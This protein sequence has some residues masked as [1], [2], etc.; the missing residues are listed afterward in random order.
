MGTS[1]PY[2]ELEYLILAMV[3]ENI[4]SGYAMRKEMNRMRGGRWSA[5]SGSVYRV[6]RRLEKDNLLLEARRVGVPNRERTEYELTPHGEALLHSWLTFPPDRTELAFLVDPI[7]T[8]SYFLG[9]LRTTEQMR[10][11]KT[12]LQESK[13]FVAD[14]RRDL[15]ATSFNRPIQDAAYQNLL[16]LAEARHEW[17]K[18]LL[19]QIKQVSGVPAA[20]VGVADEEI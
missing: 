6:L 17:L 16:Y 15:E 19:S 18:K 3:G 12:W 5:E 8:R 20:A 7:R 10:V 9:R 14:L 4:S 2:S 11:V 13:H 1:G